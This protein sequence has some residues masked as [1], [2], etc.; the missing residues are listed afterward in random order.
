MSPH[1]GFTIKFALITC[2]RC[3]AARVRGVEC[4][5]CGMKPAPWEVDQNRLT[6][7][8]QLAEIVQLL[9]SNPTAPAL[10]S[11][12]FADSGLFGQIEPLVGELLSGFR[13]FA[14]PDGQTDWLHDAVTAFVDLRALVRQVDHLRPFIALVAR[15]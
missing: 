6:R 3:H 15:C 10:T 2:S 5:D 4:P 9:D 12:T 13:R 14:G 7:Q 1:Y 8:R 11:W